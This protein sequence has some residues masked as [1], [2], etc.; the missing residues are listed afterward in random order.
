MVVYIKLGGPWG[1]IMGTLWD[2]MGPR[3]QGP[4]SF[5]YT[6]C[7]FICS[8]KSLKYKTCFFFKFQNQAFYKKLDF[9]NIKTRFLYQTWGRN[10]YFFESTIP[11]KTVRFQ[12]DSTEW[13]TTV[14]LFLPF[15]PPDIIF[16]RFFIFS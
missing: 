13:H 14:Y 4:P 2:P 11:L 10:D 8:K 6:T 16:V 5:M 9:L 7:F 3:P 1:P 15:T 12:T